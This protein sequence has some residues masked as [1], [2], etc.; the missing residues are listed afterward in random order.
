M[1]STH[2]S[3]FYELRSSSENILILIFC[4][5]TK[6]KREWCA[7][8]RTWY[9]LKTV[10]CPITAISQNDNNKWNRVP[11]RF[12]FIAFVS[13]VS[14]DAMRNRIYAENAA[15]AI[16]LY[17]F[18]GEFGEFVHYFHC[19]SF[20]IRMNELIAIRSVSRIKNRKIC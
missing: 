3:H 20:G 8:K 1:L 5:L 13:S 15:R 17:D 9:N 2:A 12:V 16:R 14:R 7:Q 6:P 4:F 19:L 11:T 10:S 18:F